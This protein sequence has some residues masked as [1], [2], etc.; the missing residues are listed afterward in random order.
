MEVRVT[1][2]QRKCAFSEHYIST[3]NDVHSDVRLATA[4]PLARQIR[5][6]PTFRAAARGDK[7]IKRKAIMA[8]VRIRDGTNVQKYPKID[9][10]SQ[11]SGH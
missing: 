6:L 9:L 3:L 11:R 5:F 4:K 10:R 1:R 2:R 8:L 7:G